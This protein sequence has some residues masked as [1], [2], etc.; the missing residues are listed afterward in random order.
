MARPT[1]EPW[2]PT[3]RAGWLADLDPA[4]LQPGP[5]RFV[6]AP[7][8]AVDEVDGCVLVE[9]AGPPAVLRVVGFAKGDTDEAQDLAQPVVVEG[10]LTVIRHPARGEFRAVELQV[11][12]LRLRE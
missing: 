5:G 7:G 8:S 10:V 2:A 4:R 1:A 11:R 12:L 6:F 9:A 3:I